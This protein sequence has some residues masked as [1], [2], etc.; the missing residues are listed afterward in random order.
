M[1]IG[2]LSAA[3][4]LTREALR[5]YEKR[6]LLVARRRGNGYRDYPP[7]AVEWMCY[8]RS[9]QALGFTLAEIETGLPLLASP[10]ASA[11]LLREALQ[12]K[13]SDIDERIAGLA[14][15]RANLTRRLE[16]PTAGC[17]LQADWT[18]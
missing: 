6:G 18:S 7:E 13:L 12:R 8:L 1:R 9:A 11:P 2:E 16:E 10:A 3:T 5:F 15:L 17:P 4:G 14:A